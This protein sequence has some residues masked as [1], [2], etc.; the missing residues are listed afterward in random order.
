[1]V[2]CFKGLSAQ[3]RPPNLDDKLDNISLQLKHPLKYAAPKIEGSHRGEEH[4]KFALKLGD[5]LF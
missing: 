5:F 1:M 4:S 3:V 2:S